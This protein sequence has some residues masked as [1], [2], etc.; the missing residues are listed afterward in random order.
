MMR[1]DSDTNI[2]Q[3]ITED[4][5]F[6]RKRSIFETMSSESLPEFP[7]YTTTDLY[8]ISLGTYQ[9][10]QAVFYY[11]EHLKTNGKYISQI[12]TEVER[13]DFDKY[14]IS[15]ENPLLIKIRIQS[16]HSGNTKYCLFIL[17]ED[18]NNENLESIQES[19]SNGNVM[20]DAQLSVSRH[21]S[22]IIESLFYYCQCKNG[23]RTIGCCAHVMSVI[24][25]LGHARYFPSV[26]TPARFL[27]DFFYKLPELTEGDEEL[28]DEDS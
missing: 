5:G 23:A 17:T 27:D 1:R 26:T 10:K 4:L 15:L 28:S 11:S 7:R 19:T 14:G 16:R 2:L 6:V 13:I 20:V 22:S 9:L 18:E 24:W 12:C 25:F 21:P 8:F 3:V